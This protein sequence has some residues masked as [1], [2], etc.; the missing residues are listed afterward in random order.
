MTETRGRRTLSKA[1]GL[2]SLQEA[3]ALLSCIYSLSTPLGRH[4][5]DFGEGELG[6]GSGGVCKRTR[7]WRDSRAFS[8][9]PPG[10]GTRRCLAPRPP[11]W[12]RSPES[13]GR[14]SG[15]SDGSRLGGGR[16][17]EAPNSKPQPKGDRGDTGVL[18]IRSPSLL[19][20]I[21]RTAPGRR[22]EPR[23]HST[24]AVSSG[25]GVLAPGRPPAYKA[26]ARGC[27]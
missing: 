25:Q 7:G 20:R 27:D 15:S 14:G 2:Q 16:E 17:L 24:E 26:V 13:P 6:E 5:A 12:M 22:G 21:R 8:E 1:R 23:G 4:H 3:G 11:A 10:S 19:V 18:F 9:Q